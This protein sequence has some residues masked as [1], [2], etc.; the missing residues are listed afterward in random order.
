MVAGT[1]LECL[2]LNAGSA[3]KVAEGGVK[4]TRVAGNHVETVDDEYL[5]YSFYPY[6]SL[7]FFYSVFLLNKFLNSLNFHI[8]D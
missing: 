4:S 2:G 5:K 8:Y 3:A 6:V 7:S 1:G